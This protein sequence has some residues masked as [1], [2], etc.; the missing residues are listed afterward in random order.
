MVDVTVFGTAAAD[1]IVQVLRLPMPGDQLPAT[2]LGWRLGGGSA[3][4]A[5]G[6]AAAGHRVQLVGAHGNDAIA[7]ALLAAL[8]KRGVRT[9]QMFSV[10]APSPRALILLDGNGERAIL[11][12][13]KDLVTAAYPLSD[14]PRVARA[15]GVYVETYERFPTTIAD[16][17]ADA[18]LVASPPTPT[19]PS[20]PADIIIGSERQF[21]RS[22]WDAPFGPLQRIA[23][24]RLRWVVI[25]RG[26]RGADAYAAA[27]SIHVDAHHPV[28]Q[29]DATGAGDAFA[30]CLMSALLNGRE[31]T[32]AMTLAAAAGAATIEMLQSIPAASIEDLCGS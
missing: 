29:V 19:A 30:A 24:S 4:L 7:E 17:E 18:L 27:D 14:P 20:W 2:S 5:C 15:G 16:R 22:W 32:E 11:T 28:H 1:V 12:L 8:R 10:D 31:M 6:V 23:G 21:P 13:D 25:T 3:N 9:D 26:A